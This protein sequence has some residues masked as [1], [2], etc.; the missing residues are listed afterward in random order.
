MLTMATHPDERT[1]Q[2]YW[3]YVDS[4]FIYVDSKFGY[5]PFHLSL[6]QDMRLSD[7]ILTIIEKLEHVLYIERKKFT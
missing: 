4:K 1:G 6:V 2:I 3:I 7:F 5:W